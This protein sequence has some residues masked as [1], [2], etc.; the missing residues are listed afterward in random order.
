LGV[1]VPSVPVVEPHV[2]GGS[3]QNWPL[4]QVASI[5]HVSADGV[6]R[7]LRSVQSDRLSEPI[8]SVVEPVGHLLH[9]VA[10]PSS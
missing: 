6:V 4:A 2:P 1:Q 3:L 8:D 9:D 5:T 10:P 7:P